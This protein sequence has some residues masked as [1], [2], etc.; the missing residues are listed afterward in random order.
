MQ[1]VFFI[2]CFSIHAILTGTTSSEL[3]ALNEGLKDLLDGIQVQL[4]G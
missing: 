1:I 3:D 2:R 4:L